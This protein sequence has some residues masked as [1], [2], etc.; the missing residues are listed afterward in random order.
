MKRWLVIS[1]LTVLIFL[2]AGVEGTCFREDIPDKGHTMVNTNSQQSEI[3]EVS[4]MLPAEPDKN[5]EAKEVKAE[6]VKQQ[7]A[8]N[9]IE[10]LSGN[11]EDNSNEQKIAYLTF[12]DGPSADTTPKVLT[13]LE[14]YNVKATFFVLGKCAERNMDIVRDTVEKG[15]VLGNHTQYHQLKYSDLDTFKN[16]FEMN[17]KLIEE[18]INGYHMEL[19]RPPGGAIPPKYCFEYLNQ[20]NI[21]AVNWHVDSLDSRKKYCGSKEAIV[22]NTING[23][24]GFKGKKIIILC[25]DG[26]GHGATARALPEI[27]EYLQ[28]NGFELR[29]LTAEEA[30]SIEEKW[31]VL[32]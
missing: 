16:H 24:K 23:I 28:E 27:I 20:N 10:P 3:K 14:S 12:D 1:L 22:Q 32:N 18:N 30:L 21:I 25:H 26:A 11:K 6:P 13:V 17:E 29:A 8:E 31:V 19:F 9:P 4:V 7:P 5:V 2:L 15:H